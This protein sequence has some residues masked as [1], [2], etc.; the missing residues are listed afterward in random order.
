MIYRNGKA[1]ASTFD[2][3]PSEATPYTGSDS[4]IQREK[5]MNKWVR[6]YSLP[7]L[8]GD[9]VQRTML[10]NPYDRSAALRAELARST[11]G[12]TRLPWNDKEN[13]AMQLYSADGI[14]PQAGD[15]AAPGA[16][17]MT[18]NRHPGAMQSAGPVA[19]RGSV[20]GVEMAV[21]TAGNYLNGAFQSHLNDLGLTSQNPSWND[22]QDASYNQT[23]PAQRWQA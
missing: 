23:T 17:P 15:G 12:A 8:V 16:L 3:F 9:A 18:S 10:D 5:R 11:A 2:N 22:Y 1:Q 21:P 7:S 14:N 20:N 4:D 13:L 6:S 19:S